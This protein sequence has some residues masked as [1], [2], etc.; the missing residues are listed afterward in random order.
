V[1]SELRLL[2]TV[3]PLG[4]SIAFWLFLF[5]GCTSRHQNNHQQPKYFFHA[6]NLFTENTE[7]PFTILKL[8]H[9]ISDYF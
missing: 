4:T 3:I 5:V 8:S 6:I 9:T 1:K 2:N 7:Y